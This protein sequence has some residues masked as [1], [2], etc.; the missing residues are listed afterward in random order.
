MKENNK[1][2]IKQFLK[3]LFFLKKLRKLTIFK[4]LLKMSN[5]ERNDYCLYKTSICFYKT[6]CINGKE[7]VYAHTNEEIEPIKCWFNYQGYCENDNCQYWHKVDETMEEFYIRTQQKNKPILVDGKKM[8]RILPKINDNTNKSVL[9]KEMKNIPIIDI[10]NEQIEN[11]KQ[12]TKEIIEQL[13]NEEIV[14]KIPINIKKY[15]YNNWIEQDKNKEI[16]NFED[17]IKKQID[18][19]PV[20]F[21]EEDNKL[22]KIEQ[23]EEIKPIVNIPIKTFV[24]NRH[25]TKL[26]FIDYLEQLKYLNI[27]ILFIEKNNKNY[28]LSMVYDEEKIKKLLENEED[29]D[30]NLPF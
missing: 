8:Y 1:K 10:T 15:T 18:N 9:R 7:C 4:T 21:T 12:K 30:N 16:P 23:Q 14:D 17:T 29:D 19:P 3:Q 26:E 11:N 2:K 28:K 20:Y 27:E 25:L 5:K 22:E 24:I 6:K 13:I